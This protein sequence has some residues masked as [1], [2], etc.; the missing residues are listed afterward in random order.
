ML[1]VDRQD[2]LDGAWSFLVGHL[3]RAEELPTAY[4]AD[5]ITL[6]VNNW[7]ACTQLNTTTLASVSHEVRRTKYCNSF[8][9]GLMLAW[10]VQV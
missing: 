9:F 1:L 3:G 6:G 8:L 2:L 7:Q 4:Q 10:G 5:V